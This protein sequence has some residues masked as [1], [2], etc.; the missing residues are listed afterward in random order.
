M[1]SS[2][3]YLLR[4]GGHESNIR[5]AV[6]RLQLGSAQGPILSA[7]GLAVSRRHRESL[8]LELGERSRRGKP[9]WAQGQFGGA[10]GTPGWPFQQ[11]TVG[12]IPT[13]LALNQGIF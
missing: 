6:V 3:D 13:P 1:V 10:S 2:C 4:N 5:R 8:G 12:I 7:R 11:D 9:S